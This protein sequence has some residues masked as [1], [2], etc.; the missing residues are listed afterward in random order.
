MREI[1]KYRC[2]VEGV[3]PGE[4]LSKGN[5]KVS[6]ECP[7]YWATWEV[8]LKRQGAADIHFSNGDRPLVKNPSMV[9]GCC[10]HLY[11]L[12]HNIRAFGI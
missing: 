6:C 10:K 1:Q 11:R 3:N 7:D 12:L 8:A 2:T 9:P 4:R 5:V